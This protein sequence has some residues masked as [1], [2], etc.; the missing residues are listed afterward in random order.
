MEIK[1]GQY[2]AHEYTDSDGSTEV[3]IIKIKEL[4]YR[5]EGDYAV[6][7][8]KIYSWIRDETFFK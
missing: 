3:N 7:D 2:Y 8:D 4:P 1:V 5:C 6:I